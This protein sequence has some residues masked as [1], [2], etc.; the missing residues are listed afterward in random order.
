MRITIILLALGSC[1]SSA[2]YDRMNRLEASRE[3]AFEYCDVLRRCG[4]VDDAALC[5]RHTVHHLCEIGRGCDFILSD[6]R[7]DNLSLCLSDI[8]FQTCEEVTA[9]ELPDSCHD[10]SFPDIEHYPSEQR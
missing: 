6:R 9:G 7:L 5:A 8:K 1:T 3:I 10:A 2:V 4:A